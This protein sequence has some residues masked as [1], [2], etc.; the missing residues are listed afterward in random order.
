MIRNKFTY[1]FFR[2]PLYNYNISHA[3][4]LISNP[5]T[6]D[7]EGDFC[8]YN[9]HI[10]KCAQSLDK[11]ESDKDLDGTEDVDYSD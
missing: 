5:I 3:A 1:P 8:A 4:W 2:E 6:L 11:Y 10:N 7:Q 9:Y